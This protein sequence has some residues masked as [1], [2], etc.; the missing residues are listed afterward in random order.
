MNE[1]GRWVTISGRRVFIRTNQH[2]M[3]AFIRKPKEVAPKEEEHNGN[4]VRINKSYGEWYYNKEVDYEDA[5]NY[6]YHLGGTDAN[7]KQWNWS[8]P[9]FSE[10]REFIKADDE[11]KERY[12]RY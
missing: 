7:G 9:Y 8:T 1:Q 11:Q 4:K 2:P 10:V 6:I 5:S 12:L 3:N